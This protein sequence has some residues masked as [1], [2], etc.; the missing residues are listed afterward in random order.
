MSDYLFLMESRVSPEQW[1]ALLLVGRTAAELGINTYL[2][3]GAIRDLVAGSPIDDLDFVAEGK[4]LKVAKELSR[5]GV[6]VISENEALQTAELEF[7]KGVLGSIS[8]ARTET[9]PKPGAAPTITPSGIIADL[10]RR[11]FPMNSIGVSLSPNS[12][13]LL[14][15]PTNGLADLEKREIRAQH[16]YT[17]L[18]DPVRM[19]RGVR[20]KARLG[21]AWDPKT[22]S[23]FQTAR[24][25]GMAELA[26]GEGLAHELRAIARE[27]NPIPILKE[28]EK[29]KLLRGVHPKLQGAALN[30]PALTRVAKASMLLWAAGM[31]APSFPLFLHFLTQKLSARDQ[32]QLAE[33]IRLSKSERALPQKLEAEAKRAAKELGGKAG[34]TPT[35]LY[36]LLSKTPADVLLLLLTEFPQKTVQSRLKTYFSKYLPLRA[37]PPAKE[38]EQLGVKANTPRSQ[39]IADAYFFATIEGELRTPGQQQKFLSRL[40]QQIR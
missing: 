36:Q 28:L 34:A 33:K 16:N 2:V 22:T 1:Q 10:R 19:F 39:K 12:R 21:F 23:Q 8:M 32:G 18:D 7:P 15:D 35:K 40:A 37:N 26:V 20:L 29:E 30:W 3:G 17:F 14:L 24:E 13:G 11:D 4:A 31:R 25:E 27:R 5:R 6:K 9:Y 38:L